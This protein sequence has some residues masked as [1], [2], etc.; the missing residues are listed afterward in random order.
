MFC[1]FRDRN[2]YYVNQTVVHSVVTSFVD[3]S[4]YKKKAPLE[5]I[6]SNLILFVVSIF[7]VSFKIMSNIFN[8]TYLSYKLNRWNLV[9]KYAIS[10][11]LLK[12]L[13]NIFIIHHNRFIVKGDLITLVMTA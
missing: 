5:V 12:S 11:D 7:I 8:A 1:L 9:L 3:V 13:G 4:E 6:Y 2:G 10:I